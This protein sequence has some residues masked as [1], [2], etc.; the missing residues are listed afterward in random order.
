[1]LFLR[2]GGGGG[3]LVCKNRTLK[4]YFSHTICGYCTVVYVSLY[5]NRKVPGLFHIPILSAGSRSCPPSPGKQHPLIRKPDIIYHCKLI[6]RNRLLK[7]PEEIVC[8]SHQQGT[9][10]NRVFFIPAK[11]PPPVPYPAFSLYQNHKK[12]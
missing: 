9:V 2:G 8:R 12:D 11:R 4:L 10:L 3:A 7:C 6:I 5:C 1:M